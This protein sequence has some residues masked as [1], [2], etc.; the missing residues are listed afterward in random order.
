MLWS[1]VCLDEWGISYL[2]EEHLETI[3]K[4]TR[5]FRYF[6]VAYIEVKQNPFKEPRAKV[7]AIF[8]DLFSSHGLKYVNLSSQS[9][10]H[11]SFLQGTRQLEY[12]TVSDC[13]ALKDISPISF[14]KNWTFLSHNGI[15]VSEPW[16]LVVSNQICFPRWKGRQAIFRITW[17][18]LQNTLQPFVSQHRPYYWR[19]I[20]IFILS[21][22]IW[23]YCQQCFIKW[24]RQL[25]S[26]F[27]ISIK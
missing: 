2:N 7:Y 12:L 1:T 10:S 27:Q 6:S 21:K 26:I 8:N 14:C 4:H 11:L 16:A 19:S 5:G 23:Y 22:R 18:H 20:R 24:P 15:I 13:F 3:M 9:I 17:K 25:R